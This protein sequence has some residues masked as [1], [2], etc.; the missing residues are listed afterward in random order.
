MCLAVYTLAGSKVLRGFM[1]STIADRLGIGF[2]KATEMADAAHAAGLVR[3]EHGTVLLTGEGQE[4]GATLTAPG[5][6]RERTSEKD[7]PL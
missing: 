5:S 7:E 1:V 6:S 4:R 3:H 2:Y